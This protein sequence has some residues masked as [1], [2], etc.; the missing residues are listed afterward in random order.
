[1]PEVKWMPKNPCEGCGKEQEA[2]CND[3]AEYVCEW[4]DT[5][6][7]QLAAQK[8]LMEYLIS[9]TANVSC[10]REGTQVIGQESLE[11]ILKEIEQCQK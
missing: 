8:Q 9:R 3:Y 7:S 10:Y 2:R 1:M 4:R 11:S 5:Y 6:K